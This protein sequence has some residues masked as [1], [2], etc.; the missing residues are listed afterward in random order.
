MKSSPQPYSD[1][2]MLKIFLFI[3][4]SELASQKNYTY[5]QG[6]GTSGELLSRAKAERDF[7]GQKQYH[8][9]DPRQSSTR[10]LPVN[11]ISKGKII[12]KPY[13]KP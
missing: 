2:A 4:W 13:L 8:G 9:P 6:R 11:M 5:K 7:G 10:H 12:S 1:K 3:S